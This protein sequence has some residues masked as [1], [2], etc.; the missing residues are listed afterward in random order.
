MLSDVRVEYGRIFRPLGY[1][2]VYLLHY[3]VTDIPFHFQRDDLLTTRNLQKVK[4]KKS[5]QCMINTDKDAKYL[6][7]IFTWKIYTIIKMYMT[8]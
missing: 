7:E 5:I 6:T 1:E 8:M 2:R 3:K 4:M